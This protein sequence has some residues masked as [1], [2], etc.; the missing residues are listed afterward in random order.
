MI[1]YHYTTI[2]TKKV[3]VIFL[4]CSM[5]KWSV[6]K[7][8]FIYSIFCSEIL[9]MY[10]LMGGVVNTLVTIT[11]QWQILQS[12]WSICRNWGITHWVYL[13]SGI[14]TYICTLYCEA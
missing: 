10:T 2:Y 11:L 9:S 4:M 3:L 7:D 14:N 5:E 8:F 12:D 6:Y 13:W 1:N